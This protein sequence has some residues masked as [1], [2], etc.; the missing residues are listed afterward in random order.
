MRILLDTHAFLWM[1]DEDDKLSPATRSA[2]Q[3]PDNEIIVSVVSRNTCARNTTGRRRRN[4]R[5][6]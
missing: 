5:N 3:A 6:R 2:I 1:A 4:L